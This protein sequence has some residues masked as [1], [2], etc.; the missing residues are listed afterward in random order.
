MKIFWRT[1]TAFFVVTWLLLLVVGRTKLFQDP[2]T[3]WHTAVGQRMI[4][5]GEFVRDDVFTFTRGGEPWIAQ[6][7]LG[8][9]A[10]AAGYSLGGWDTLLLAATTLLA[11]LFAWLAARLLRAGLHWLA[12]AVIL[13]LVAAASSHSFHVRPHLVT[14]L[15][16][17]VT[18]AALLDVEAK[19]RPLS[20]LLWLAPL[21]LLWANT[22]GGVLG[23]IATVVLTLGGWSVWH[24]CR[25]SSPF[26][27]PRRY[28]AA[29]G[30]LATL[31]AVLF[32]NPFGSDLPRAWLQ[33]LGMKLPELIA[34]HSP[35]SLRSPEAW[36]ALALL[37]ACAGLLVSV[38]VRCW[39]AT[40]F[41]PFVWFLLAWTRVRHAPLFAIVGTLAVADML[42]HTR[43]ADWLR[44]NDYL[45]TPA[46][47]LGL[48]PL[49]LPIGCVL[50]AFCVQAA[51]LAVPVVGAG[52][53]RFDQSKWP[54]ELLPELQSLAARQPGVRLFNGLNLGG[55]VEFHTPEL[56]TFIDDRCELFDDTFL[57]KYCEAEQTNPAQLDVWAAA[58]DCRA[59]LVGRGT[60]FD[61]YLRTAIRWRLL[62][63]DAA[64]SLYERIAD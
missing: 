21:F 48:Q 29:A 22:H 47:K 52:W 54:N 1:E 56:R 37:A 15:L 39:R 20:H 12:T 7:W 34:E 11:A 2:G 44:R 43:L 8:E 33:I 42:P 9:V 26:D 27:G 45:R 53:V 30:I 6:Q 25:R 49:L 61:L 10:M 16:T 23:G 59:A 41:L 55:F 14:M 19:R 46:K 63:A 58:H 60:P 36:A 38:P 40:W 57:A 50:V 35:L 64:A 28:L 4:V 3:F 31:G 62:R 24:L 18:F 17:G 32:V 13:V 5:T 51:G